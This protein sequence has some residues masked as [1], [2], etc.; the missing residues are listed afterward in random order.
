MMQRN[1]IL[2]FLNSTRTYGTYTRHAVLQGSTKTLCGRSIDNMEHSSKLD[3]SCET[4][5][6][7]IVLRK[8]LIKKPLI[9]T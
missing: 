3:I 6:K 9:W 5:R 4:C 1:K 7:S 2:V 8:L